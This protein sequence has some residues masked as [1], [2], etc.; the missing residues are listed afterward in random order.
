[1][2]EAIENNQDDVNVMYDQVVEAFNDTANRYS[3]KWKENQQR[4]GLHLEISGGKK[5][6]QAKE[7]RK[8]RIQ[9]AL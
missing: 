2:I 6:T 7:K 3:E 8:C 9:Q 1:M 5:E 4:N